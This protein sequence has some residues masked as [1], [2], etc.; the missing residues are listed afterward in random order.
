MPISR[1]VESQ[2]PG[3]KLSNTDFSEV[4]SDHLPKLHTV[5]ISG[6]SALKILNF[7]TLSS[8]SFAG[9]AGQE[10]EIDRDF[11]HQRLI[12]FFKNAEEYHNLDL[13]TL[14]ET[15]TTLTHNIGEAL[16]INWEILAEDG[17]RAVLYNVSSLDKQDLQKRNPDTVRTLT[18][19]NEDFLGGQLR[20]LQSNRTVAIFSIHTPHHDYPLTVQESIHKLGAEFQAYDYTLVAGDFNCRIAHTSSSEIDNANSLVPPPCRDNVTVYD[21]TDGCFVLT[22]QVVYQN[23]GESL[24]PSEPSAQIVRRSAQGLLYW[25]SDARPYYPVMFSENH[26]LPLGGKFAAIDPSIRINARQLQEEMQKKF[27]DISIQ[28]YVYATR[29]NQKALVIYTQSVIPEFEKHGLKKIEEEYYSIQFDYSP[30]LSDKLEFRIQDGDAITSIAL[31]DLTT[32]EFLR[33]NALAL[34]HKALADFRST[35]EAHKASPLA[36]SASVLFRE[37]YKVTNDLSVISTSN[38][39]KITEAMRLAH[40]AVIDPATMDFERYIELTNDALGNKRSWSRQIGGAMLCCLGM[41]ACA[42]AVDASLA[43][44]GILTPMSLATMGLGVKLISAGI[45]LV[46]AAVGARLAIHA[47]FFA[48]SST[49]IDIASTLEAFQDEVL[50][51]PKNLLPST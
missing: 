21:F 42:T 36:K 16:G 1:E 22:G 46:I 8:W 23:D 48:T 45:A 29:F 7:N 24:L 31:S 38:L 4:Y 50:D 17:D 14:Q 15:E 3:G 28:I 25:R 26:E 32:V 34:F 27:Q 9:F 41:I 11:R 44:F 18:C 49:R 47:G 2:L 6:D 37:F 19:L 10:S 30:F 12:E 40:Q 13:I 20:H 51:T 43:S 33:D 39:L 5:K 35:L